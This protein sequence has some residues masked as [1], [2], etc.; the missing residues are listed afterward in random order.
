MIF[1]PSAIIQ[2]DKKILRMV[3]ILIFSDSIEI[4]GKIWGN[5]LLRLL[6][7]I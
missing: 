6:T 5:V 3:E 1:T 2:S 7:V 4:I